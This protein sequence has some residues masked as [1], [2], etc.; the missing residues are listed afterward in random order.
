MQRDIGWKLVADV[1]YVGNA[2]RNQLITSRSTAGRTATPISRR[3]WIR[4]TSSGGRRSRCPTIFCVRIAGYGAI[5]QREFTG[6]S[7]LPLDAVL[8]EP[9]AHVGRTVVRRGLHL[10]DRQ[11]DAR[12][13]RSVRV[14]TTARRQLQLERPPAAHADDQ[15]L[16]RGAE[17]QPEVGQHRRSRRIFDNWQIS[18]ITSILSGTSRRLH[19]QLLRTCRPA[20]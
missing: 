3:A 19:L 6:Y 1:A 14:A 15:L 11:Q 2:A 13:D 17:P 9:P 16:V 10:S 7:R 8:G 12:H 20:R 5:T 4:P 18:G